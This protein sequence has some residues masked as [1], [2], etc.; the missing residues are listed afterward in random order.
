MLVGG[1]GKDKLFGGAGNDTLDARDGKRDTVDCGAGRRDLARVDRRDR[2]RRCERV[3]RPR[4][5]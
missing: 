3:K 1:R 2:V 4:R 5:R